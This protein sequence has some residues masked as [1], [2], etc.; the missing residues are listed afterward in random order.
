MEPSVAATDPVIPKVYTLQETLTIA[1]EFIP[2]FLN[3]LRIPASDDNL[4]QIALA[5][6]HYKKL[7]PTLTLKLKQLLAKTNPLN[8]LNL[9]YELDKLIPSTIRKVEEL[10]DKVLLN[11]IK[12]NN[13]VDPTIGIVDRGEYF[14]IDSAGQGIYLPNPG[15]W[16]H[17][18]GIREDFDNETPILLYGTINIK[19][20]LGKDGVRTV[21]LNEKDK[22]FKNSLQTNDGWLKCVTIVIFNELRGLRRRMKRNP[23][24]TDRYYNSD[25]FKDMT[26]QRIIL[27]NYPTFENASKISSNYIETDIF[28]ISNIKR[29]EYLT[30]VDE[31]TNK[32][33]GYVFNFDRIDFF[34]ISP[35]DETLMY[36]RKFTLGRTA[37]KLNNFQAVPI[38]PKIIE[39]GTLILPGLQDD[40][41]II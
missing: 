38:D 7:D 35:I 39:D 22:L 36:D 34:F 16:R 11:N 40:V 6:D 5:L 15:M 33:D 28:E 4:G 19:S 12:A 2:V 30:L 41:Y 10:T 14:K 23:D 13:L 3:V 1:P 20:L 9:I 8:R 17:I 25:E 31:L 27:E 24:D 26:D 29:S 37:T 32:S 18:Q 21:G